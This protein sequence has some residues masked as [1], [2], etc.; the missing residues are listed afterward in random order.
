MLAKN[1]HSLGIYLYKPIRSQ[2]TLIVI[3]ALP[4]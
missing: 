3:I 1:A 4:H 2:Y